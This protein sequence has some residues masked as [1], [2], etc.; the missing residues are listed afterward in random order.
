MILTGIET[1]SWPI[2]VAA[3]SEANACGR[4]LFGTAGSNPAGGTEVSLSYKCCVLSEGGLCDG[5]IPRPEQSTRWC[6]CVR[7]CITVCV[8]VQQ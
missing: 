1:C 4:S 7:A 2:Q 8:Q 3:L 6:V 5:P